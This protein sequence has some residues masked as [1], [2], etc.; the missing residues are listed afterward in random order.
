[1][2]SGLSIFSKIDGGNGPLSFH[3]MPSIILSPLHWN[4]YKECRTLFREVFDISEH[5]E[6]PGEWRNRCERRSFV[7]L[8]YGTVIGFILVDADNSIRYICVSREFQNGKV[9]TMLLTKVIQIN[10][11]RTLRL[12]T[13]DITRLTKWYERFGFR[14]TEMFY[15]AE[16]SFEGA[17]MVRLPKQLGKI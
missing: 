1:M 2:V 11:R 15:D 17:E 7:A 5:A 16:G 10:D 6:F 8:Y 9:G 13:A 4:Y 14:V 3:R 12:V